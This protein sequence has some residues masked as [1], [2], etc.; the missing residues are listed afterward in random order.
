MAANVGLYGS[1]SD[2]T[3]VAVDHFEEP[4]TTNQYR[5]NHNI[6]RDIRKS[7]EFGMDLWRTF[8][9]VARAHRILRRYI[10]LDP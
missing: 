4:S 2:T 3:L 6:N 10:S 1:W 9:E 7:F 5:L 8:T